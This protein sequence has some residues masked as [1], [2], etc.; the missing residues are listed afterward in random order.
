MHP[1]LM[2]V[3][4]IAA[5]ALSIGTPQPTQAFPPFKDKEG[6]A[7]IYCHNKPTGGARNYRGMYYKAHNLTFAE[8]DDAA[9]AK[10]A[11]VA[12]AEDPSPNVKPKTWTAPKAGTNPEEKKMTTAEARKKAADAEKAYNAKKT[13]AALKK[14]YATALSNL[15]HTIMLDESITPSNRYPEAL[16]QL[17]A[18]LKLDPTNKQAKEDVKQIEDAYKSMGRPI[19]PKK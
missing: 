18:A 15:G 9:E 3:A 16:K 6:K 1:A 12:V 2:V 10:K 7:C 8:F 14:A 17:R 5:L 4:P 13:D 19:P 11:G